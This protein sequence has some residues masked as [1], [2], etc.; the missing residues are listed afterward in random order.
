MSNHTTVP[1]PRVLAECL[2]GG[3]DALSSFVIVEYIDGKILSPAAFYELSSYERSAFYQSLADFY[4]QLR[5]QEFSSIG[6]LKMGVDGAYIGEKTATLVMNM[7]QLEGLDPWSIQDSHHNESG[8]LK[9]ANTYTKMLLHF[10]YNAFL[11]SRNAVGEGMGL[12]YLYNHFLFTKRAQ[13]WLNP[14]LDRGPFVLVHGDLSLSNLLLDRNMNIVGVL[15][16]EWSRVV[17]VQYFMPPLWFTHRDEAQ[18]A[19]PDSWTLYNKKHFSEFL[20]IVKSRE[21]ELHGS[22]LLHDEWAKN[23]EDINPLI[24]NALENWTEI[25]WLVHQ[26]IFAKD[27]SGLQDDLAV[28]AAED[29]LRG[30]LAEVK[31]QDFRRYKRELEMLEADSCKTQERVTKK[32]WRHWT[33][34]WA[35]WLQKAPSG[36]TIVTFTIAASVVIAAVW[37][38]ARLRAA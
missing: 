4:I 10:T 37:S 19:H 15:D 9:S 7:M 3:P 16:W 29:P 1:V 13:K 2:D 30:M 35:T 38:R 11:K 8:S 26:N 12:E 23:M 36:P 34:D 28:F 25:D 6:R 32:S 20:T 14:D 17:P 22:S 33:E 18:L 31:E 5:R 24:A 21:N 27:S